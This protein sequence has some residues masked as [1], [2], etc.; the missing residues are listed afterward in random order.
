MKAQIRTVYKM[1]RRDLDD[2]ALYSGLRYGRWAVRYEPNVA[3]K[4]KRGTFLYAFDSPK[5]A[6]KLLTREV[7]ELWEAEALVV[8]LQAYWVFPCVDSL[9][10]A[11]WQ[12]VS[13][14]GVRGGHIDLP[15]EVEARIGSSIP[16]RVGA[17]WCKW[18]KIT[19]RIK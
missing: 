3:T 18:I 6:Q 11:F 2:R 8:D 15:E 17:L 16:A 19:K 13:K 5:A 9:F 7:D 10:S 12:K 4:P 1:L 14:G